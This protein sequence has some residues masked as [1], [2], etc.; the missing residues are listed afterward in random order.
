MFPQLRSHR[1]LPVAEV[2]GRADTRVAFAGR[3]LAFFLL[4]LAAQRFADAQGHFRSGTAYVEINLIAE[5]DVLREGNLVIG[6]VKDHGDRECLRAGIA[7]TQVHPAIAD[8]VVG[9]GIV[10]E[11][12]Q[13]EG[14]LIVLP[15]VL[16]EEPAAGAECDALVAQY[17]C[18]TFRR[19][20][21]RDR[22]ACAEKAVVGAVE[23]KGSR[24]QVVAV[25][26]AG[27]GHAPAQ[28]RTKAHE[29]RLQVEQ[30][31]ANAESGVVAGIGDVLAARRDVVSADAA[32]VEGTGEA[33]ADDLL[34]V[35]P[36]VVAKGRADGTEAQLTQRTA[37]VGVEG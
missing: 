14:C 18:G 27:I 36:E 10:D 5:P 23:V 21:Q 8:G 30:V 37:L 4:A 12:A 7:Q 15:A 9:I 11:A 34:L 19:E 13:G 28:P 26:A 22:I 2:T 1:V 3:R 33:H 6:L 35:E 25:A 32:L 20:A 16:I 29:G 24:T 31:F 17:P